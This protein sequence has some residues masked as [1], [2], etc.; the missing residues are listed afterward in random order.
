MY[1]QYDEPILT[2]ILNNA[3]KLGKGQLLS[4]WEMSTV[5]LRHNGFAHHACNMFQSIFVIFLFIF[6]TI[7]RRV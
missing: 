5:I 1:Q 4:V 2:L 6:W 3:R 7:L